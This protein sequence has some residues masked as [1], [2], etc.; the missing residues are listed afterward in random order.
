MPT[1]STQQVEL[2][3]RYASM[4]K[5]VP[6]SPEQ[7]KRTREDAGLSQAQAAALVYVDHDSW[8]Q[9]EKP[10]IQKNARGMRAAI[11]ELFL[12]KVGELE[13]SAYAPQR[14]AFQRADAPAPA[15]KKTAQFKRAAP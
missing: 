12:I 11:W 3:A 1:K 9:W 6:P 4:P 10:R 7:V 14:P 5:I 8:R 2:P 15:E 13:L